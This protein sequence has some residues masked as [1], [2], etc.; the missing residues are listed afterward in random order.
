[1]SLENFI[2]IKRRRE[3]IIAQNGGLARRSCVTIA[4]C[5]KQLLAR[6]TTSMARRPHLVAHLH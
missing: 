4:A 3:T 5:N 1:M 6:L 2:L